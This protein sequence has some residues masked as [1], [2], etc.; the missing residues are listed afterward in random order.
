MPPPQGATLLV[1][2]WSARDGVRDLIGKASFPLAGISGL[3]SAVPLLSGELEVRISFGVA[4]PTGGTA[5]PA[6][7]PPS[8]IKPPSPLAK[9]PSPLAKPP[10]PLAKQPSLLKPPSQDAKPSLLGDLPPISPRGPPTPPAPSANKGP[11]AEITDEEK[12]SFNFE[13]QRARP[14]KKI[15][16]A[17]LVGKTCAPPPPPLL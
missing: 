5:E 9:P 11:S 3:P 12:A 14:R 17:P 15:E 13:G 10:S 4:I 2:V 8:P 6:R 16:A 1:D 7:Q